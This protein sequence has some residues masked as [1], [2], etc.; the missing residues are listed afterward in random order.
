MS[1]SRGQ[2][3]ADRREIYDGGRGARRPWLRTLFLSSV[4]SLLSSCNWFTDFKQQ[5]SVGTWQ[6]FST[7]SAAGKGFRGQPAGS[8]PTTGVTVAAY[9]I[10]YSNM[11]ATIDSFNVVRNP[12]AADARSLASGRMYY[13]INCAVCHG[14]AGDGNGALKQANP[15]YGFA[16]SLIMD[17]TKARSDGYLWGIIRNGRG[18]MPAYNRIEDMERWD[19]VNYLRGLQGLLG[20]PVPIG[21]TGAPGET[22]D[23]VPGATQ[24]G[25]TRPAAHLR[26]AGSGAGASQ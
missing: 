16:P 24:I 8:V 1:N 23:K 19:V 4:F 21:P 2:M 9:A 20:Q 7:D 22:G 12:V 3:T 13:A 6:H 11:P 15:M 18:I 10:S 14:D 17:V 5:P 25:P 26:P